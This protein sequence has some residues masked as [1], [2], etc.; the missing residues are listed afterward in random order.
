M[1]LTI[2]KAI[3]QGAS[4][5]RTKSQESVIFIYLKDEDYMVLNKTLSIRHVEIFD[6]KFINPGEVVKVH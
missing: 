2:V 1:C 6:E 5:I 3:Q 4:N